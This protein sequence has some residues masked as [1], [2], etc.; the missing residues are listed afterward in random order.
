MGMTVK[1]HRLRHKDRMALRK[2]GKMCAEDKAEIERL[3]ATMK[4]PTPGKIAAMVDR[5][6]ATVNWYM[7]TR[8]L[9]TRKPGRA[10]HAYVRNGKTIHPYTDEHDARIEALRVEGKVYRE[11]G[12]IV[13]REFGIERNAHS[14][15]VRIVQ[16]SAAP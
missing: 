12:E 10:P 3:A 8:G 15:Q 11:I 6:P 4:K 2:R 16:L 1:E 9:I 13:T 5:H 14:V 7:L